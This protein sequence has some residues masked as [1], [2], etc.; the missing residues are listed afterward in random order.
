M[1]V[2]KLLVPGTSHHNNSIAVDATAVSTGAFTALAI[3]KVVITTTI[4]AT[5][6]FIHATAR[7]QLLTG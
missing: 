2:I 6:I 1:A 7:Q 5:A 3:H 4:S